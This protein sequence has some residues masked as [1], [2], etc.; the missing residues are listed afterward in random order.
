MRIAGVAIARASRSSTWLHGARSGAR[1]AA[2]RIWKQLKT[3][4]SVGVAATGAAALA[5]ASLVGAGELTIAL[6]AGYAAYQV[7]RE[8]VAPGVAAHRAAEEIE[9]LG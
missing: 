2:Q 9:R 4:P 6:V 3:R 8:G 5:L 7:L 1:A